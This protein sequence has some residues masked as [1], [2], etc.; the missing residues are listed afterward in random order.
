[1]GL[2][3]G[4]CG[5]DMGDYVPKERL[6]SQ[7]AALTEEKRLL[8]AKLK[9]LEPK[10]TAAADLEKQLAAAKGEL[11]QITTRSTRT[12]ALRAAG[13]DAALLPHLEVLHTAHLAQLDEGAE[14]PD[15]AAWLTSD[16]GAKTHPLA[17]HLFAAPPAGAP[18]SGAGTKPPPPRGAPPPPDTRQNPPPPQKATPEE[19]RALLARMPT[20]TAEE[21]AAR[22]A[23][24][25]ELTG[26]GPA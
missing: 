16:T 26:L 25:R 15:F 9:E 18:A 5:E 17:A 11:Q 21:R 1:M 23:K 3:C 19:V 14:E 10:A 24:M 8:E 20:N 4:K 13:L 2:K 6:D 7:K 22:V 12:E